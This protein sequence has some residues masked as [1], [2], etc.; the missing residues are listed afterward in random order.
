M[1]TKERTT[2]IMAPVLAISFGFL[3][4]NA[5]AQSDPYPKMAPVDQYLM[6][7]NAEINWREV[8]LPIP[9]P[10]TRRSWFWDGR[11]T[12]LRSKARTALSA[13]WDEAGWECLTGPNSG[14]RR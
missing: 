9:Y 3:V 2:W 8:P 12:R 10:A 7:K 6:G 13:W 5:A 1:K 14:T 11:D 4:P